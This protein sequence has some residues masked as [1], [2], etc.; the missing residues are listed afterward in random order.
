MEM[1]DSTEGRQRRKLY[2]TPETTPTAVSLSPATSGKGSAKNRTHCFQAQ[3][4]LLH[5]AHVGDVILVGAQL[6][7]LDPFVNA[8]HHLPGDVRSIIHP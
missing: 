6:S 4:G 7:L 2:S 8:R 1:T 3:D 5:P